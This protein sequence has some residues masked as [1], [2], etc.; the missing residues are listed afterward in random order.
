MKKRIAAT[1][2]AIATM[3]TL[4][5]TACGTG[6]QD[7]THESDLTLQVITVDGREVT[8]VTYPTGFVGGI[9]CDWEGAR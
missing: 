1:T 9:D 8:C 3:L 6:G 7:S 2:G 4:T 5:L